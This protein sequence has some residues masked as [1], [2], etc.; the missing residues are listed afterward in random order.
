MERTT[1]ESR[2]DI[3]SIRYGTTLTF[4]L[5]VVLLS[6]LVVSIVQLRLEIKNCFVVI[7]CQYCF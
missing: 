7:I 2:R 1:T 4:V 6:V 3:S 5:S